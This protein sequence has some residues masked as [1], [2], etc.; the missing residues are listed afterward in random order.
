MPALFY[1]TRIS[2][3]IRVFYFVQS[4]ILL[5]LYYYTSFNSSN[6]RKYLLSQ[7]ISRLNSVIAELDSNNLI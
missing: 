2:K 3:E 1:I 7:I 5:R 6:L 4:S